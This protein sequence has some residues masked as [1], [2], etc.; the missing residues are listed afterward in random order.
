MRLPPVPNEA[1]RL[2]M[3]SRL[4]WASVL[5]VCSGTERCASAL[6]AAD[7][8]A[9]HTGSRV[10]ASS[11]DS[12]L[13]ARYREL[14]KQYAEDA[15]EAEEAAILWGQKSRA[16][17]YGGGGVTQRMTRKA[18]AREG[19]G[20]LAHSAWAVEQILR[21]PRPQRAALAG[22]EAAAPYLR[23]YEEYKAAVTAYS[24]TSLG[25]ERRALSDGADAKQLL[26]YANQYQLQG[27]AAM[28]DTFVDQ[29]EH[30]TKQAK[31]LEREAVDYARK[32]QRI[33]Q[34]L[35]TI[36]KMAVAA[37]VYAEWKE[38]PDGVMAQHQVYTY[39]VAPPLMLA[40]EEEEDRSDASAAPQSLRGQ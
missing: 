12:P 11:G 5:I 40:Q 38:N 9:S 13:L 8:L 4:F 34:T 14:T 21:D 6:I 23:A 22:E 36:D 2:A 19:I 39:T 18:L 26:A 33:K 28:A 25:Y 1:V 16:A 37:R 20:A 24:E 15:K 30:L 29:S 7:A 27:N 10:D 32:A 3:L 17:V 35:P 31:E